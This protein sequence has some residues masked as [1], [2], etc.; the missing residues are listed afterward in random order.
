MIVGVLPLIGILGLLTWLRFRVNAWVYET[1]REKIMNLVQSAWGV[2]DF[3]GSQAEAGRMTTAQ[4]QQSAMEALKVMRYGQNDYFWINDLHPRMIMHPFV[5]SLDGKDLSDVKDPTGFR[6]FVK[7]AEVCR[8]RG[9][10]LVEYMWPKPGA[11]APIPKISFVK[12]YRPWGW[13]VGSGIYMDD[14]KAELRGMLL[15]LLAG[16]GLVSSLSLFCAYRMA[17]SIAKPVQFAL[18][19]L[20]KGADQVTSAAA[21]LSSS[22]RSLAQ[23]A[24]EQAASLEETS[25]AS[26]EI[27][28]IT[29][30]NADTS[31][32]VAAD[33]ADTSRLASDANQRLG[34]MVRCMHDIDA[35]G[36]K[37]TRIIKVIDE[38]A[39]QTNILA[40]NAAVE[41][42]RGGEA[43][44]GFAVVADEVRNLA[45]RS[46]TA[47]R[48]TA[49][50]IEESVATSKLGSTKLDQ[51]TSAVCDIT[52]KIEA[53]KTRSDEVYAGSQEQAKGIEQV[54]QTIGQMDQLNQR[55]AA[56]AEETAS[57]SEELS[58]QAEAMRG[59]VGKLEALV[60]AVK[61]PSSGRL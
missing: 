34:E 8:S 21:Q 5:A 12:L 48:E 57:T 25:T 20:V 4:A 19:E 38:I 18:T 37:I 53:I 52:A 28:A 16:G 46:A 59:V 23:G 3:Y 35:S 13:I 24:T 56:V 58:A 49:G 43:G 61:T 15:V 54:S 30:R 45:Q 50:L 55:T 2:L 32:D 44:M 17:R 36:D 27:T 10:G 22:S 26:E 33:M 29:R 7:A 1:K 51:L 31:R 11:T 14:V 42:A 40:L 47:A 39:F 9:Q 60:Q 6:L 41:A